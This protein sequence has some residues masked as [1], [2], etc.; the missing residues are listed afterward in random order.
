M[1][2]VK[3]SFIAA[4]LAVAVGFLAAKVLIW[5]PVT[6]AAPDKSIQTDQLLRLSAAKDL[7]SFDD[8]YQ[9]HLGVLDTL[10]AE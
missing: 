6:V 8:K 9:R 4:S 3:L 7:P 5:P 1:K 10:R 2:K